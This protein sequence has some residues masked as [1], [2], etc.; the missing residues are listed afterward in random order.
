MQKEKRSRILFSCIIFLLAINA[1]I[2]G[3]ILIRNAVT[4]KNIREAERI[5]LEKEQE[6]KRII[7]EKLEIAKKECFKA[8]KTLKKIEALLES[9]VTW[10]N[11]SLALNDAKFELNMISATFDKSF[12]PLFWT[13]LEEIF[14]FYQLGKTVWG[15]EITATINSYKKEDLRSLC[16]KIILDY[17]LSYKSEYWSILDSSCLKSFAEP[18][19]AGKGYLCDC[20][21]KLRQVLWIEAS[22]RIREYEKETL[23]SQFSKPTP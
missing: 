7:A 15:A 4:A 20:S 12:T 10:Q 23:Q 18:H 14:H 2:W 9:G 22:K 17:H 5:K 13:Q 11:Y 3:S 16:N 1:L 21:G 6:A 19:Y 8:Y